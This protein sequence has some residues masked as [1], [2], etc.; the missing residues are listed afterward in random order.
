M[1]LYYINQLQKL[2]IFLYNKLIIKN[3]AQLFNFIAQRVRDG[4]KK[5]YKYKLKML[6]IMQNLKQNHFQ[7]KNRLRGWLLLCKYSAFQW[8]YVYIYVSCDGFFMEILIQNWNEKRTPSNLWGTV[9]SEY[10]LLFI[11][12]IHM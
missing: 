8:K 12:S 7:T 11:L 4:N 1:T 10:P 6:K 5:N 2:L 9:V 3:I